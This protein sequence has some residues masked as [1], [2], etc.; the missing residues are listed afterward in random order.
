MLRSGSRGKPHLLLKY[1]KFCNLLK[2]LMLRSTLVGYGL[3]VGTTP[4]A[5]FFPIAV[6]YLVGALT[7]LGL[8][9]SHRLE[10]VH[11]STAKAAHVQTEDRGFVMKTT[12]LT[13]KSSLSLL[14]CFAGLLSFAAPKAQAQE[15]KDPP[16]RVARISYRGRFRIFAARRARRLGQRRQESP[17][18]HRRQ[19]LGRQGFPRRIASRRCRY[20]SWQYDRSFFPQPGRGHHADAPCGRQCQLPRQ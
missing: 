3:G 4:R 12:T 6:F 5:T 11:I 8:L 17:C 16:T 9:R 2:I 20:P 14:L 7:L 13:G 1:T 18:D 15:E 19:A 10:H